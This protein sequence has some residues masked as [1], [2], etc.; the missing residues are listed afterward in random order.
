MAMA[1]MA[2]EA[3]ES[4]VLQTEDAMQTEDCIGKADRM[5]SPLAVVRTA[6]M[7]LEAAATAPGR[8]SAAAMTASML[9]PASGALTSRFG[10]HVGRP[11]TALDRLLQAAPILPIRSTDVAAPSMEGAAQV[12]GAVWAEGAAQ[13]EGAVWAEG[14]AQV[15]G[16]M[17][18][19]DAIGTEEVKLSPLADVRI[20]MVMAE[21]AATTPGK[22]SAK[23]VGACSSKAAAVGPAKEAPAV[24]PAKEAPAVGPAKRAPAAG[25]AKEGAARR[26]VSTSLAGH[27][28]RWTP[29]NGA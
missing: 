8:T 23:A 21:A 18:A 22:T 15:E 3:E 14:A 26:A 4:A 12:E 24:G 5:V 19:D 17:K 27:D 25:P 20:A 28:G 29:A 6:M 1:M 16:A 7:M 13:V 11:Q 2:M 9:L 10:G